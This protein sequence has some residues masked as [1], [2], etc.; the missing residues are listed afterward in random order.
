MRVLTGTLV[1]FVG[2]IVGVSTVG[3][4]EQG[5]PQNL[6]VLPKDMTQQ[7]VLA[8]MRTFTAGL[9]VQCTHCHAGTNQERF[10]DDKPQK[11]VARAMLKM[12]MAINE[13]HLK[14]IG[15][16]AVATK[17]TCFTCHR[18]ALKPLT[19]PAPPGGGGGGGG[20]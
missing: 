10:K 12:Q 5:G 20:Q 7:Q 2:V 13:T 6:Q 1:L 19:A 17:V 14:G 4:K 8:I 18:G 3:A 15:D 9:G 11:G 16:A